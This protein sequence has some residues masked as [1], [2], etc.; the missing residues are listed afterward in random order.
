MKKIM[1]F[2]PM[3]YIGGTEIAILSLVRNLKDYEIYI[4]Y[5]DKTSNKELL[6]KY[7]KY[8][9]VVFIDEN[10]K[11]N[12]D[13]LVLCSP[14]KTA[15]EINDRVKRDKTILWFHHFGNRED[16]IFCDDLFFD[17]VDEVVAVSETCKKIMLKQDYA[18][19]IK[20]K[21]KVIYNIIDV[22]DIIEKSNEPVD[23]EL[24]D[25]LNIVSVGRVCY[26]K[27]FERQL[28]LAK[29]LKKH[30]INFKWYIIGGN[31]Y[32]HIEKEIRDKYEELKENFVFTGFLDNPYNIIKKCDYLALLSDNETWGLVL[33]EAKALG[34][35]C[36]VTDFEV[37]YE[38]ILDN[39]TGI[40]LSRDNI[41]SYEDKIDLIVN[42]KQ[43]YKD[44]LKDFTWSNDKTLKRWAKIL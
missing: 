33:T 10:Y 8:A 7:A 34:V 6:E 11:Q 9:K 2:R 29:L 17:V 41:Q 22:K 37:A 28:M 4:G 35:P 42:N 32:E 14:Y 15:L 13:T 30:N 1:F 38:Q 16:S 19:K 23:L 24:S 31:Y 36:I 5:T 21:I 27:G 40:I 43:I 26:E 39:K 18:S 20:N 12:I 44:N 25:E 3:F